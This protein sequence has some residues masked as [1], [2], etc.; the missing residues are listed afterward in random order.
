MLTDQ[1]KKELMDFAI[2]HCNDQERVKLIRICDTLLHLHNVIMFSTD[3]E[4]ISRAQEQER[5]YAEMK[6]AFLQE[7]RKNHENDDQT[8]G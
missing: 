1:E 7:I 8:V 3:I 2:Q 5:M 4:R 6:Y